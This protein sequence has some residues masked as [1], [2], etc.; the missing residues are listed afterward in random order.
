[1]DKR[2]Y[3]PY[4]KSSKKRRKIIRIKGLKISYFT[5]LVA[6]MD[7]CVIVGLVVINSNKF[8]TFWIPTAMTTMS[9]KYLAY[10]LYDEATVNKIMSENYIEVNTEKVNLDDIVISS[11]TTTKRY[12]NNST[13]TILG[14]LCFYIIF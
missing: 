4:T 3:S 12:T 10:T 9:H 2:V 6:L 5:V 13:A 7:I 11:D 1:M 8:K 14:L